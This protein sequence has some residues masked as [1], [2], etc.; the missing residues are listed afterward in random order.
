MFYAEDVID[1]VRIGNNIVD[2]VG[3]YI[4][5]KKSGTSTYMGLCPFHKEHTPSFSVNEDKQL[6]YC[7]GCGAGGTV[8]NFIRNVENVDFP[9][10]L[11]ML[12]KRIGYKLPTAQLSEEEKKRLEY[13]NKLY[14]IHREAARFFYSELQKG[15]NA[16]LATSYLNERKVSSHIRVKYGLGVSP[17]FGSSLCDFLKG[18][19]YNEKE[20]LGSGLVSKSKKNGLL[21]DRFTDRLIFPIIDVQ[22]RIIGFG[23]RIL[24]NNNKETAKYLNSP[25]TLIFNKSNN[26]YSLNFAR[27]SGTRSFILVEGYMDVISLSQAGFNNAVAALGTAFNENHAKVLKRYADDVVILFDSDSA[28][29]KAVLRAIPQ[30]ENVGINPRVLQ[31][32]EAK[33]PDEYIKKF[34]PEAFNKLLETAKS[35]IVFQI[36]V[37][38]KNYNL[39]N[40]K[41]LA[42][43]SKETAKII[44][45]TKSAVEREIY[46]KEASKITGISE[47]AI[48]QD[49]DAVSKS[50]ASY[51]FNANRY[52]IN[53]HTSNNTAYEE[54]QKSIINIITTNSVARNLIKDIV[55]EEEFEDDVYKKMY[56]KICEYDK[57]KIEISAS[58][59]AGM[60]TDSENQRKASEVYMKN[61]NFE[62]NEML[63]KALNDQ[64]YIIKKTNIVSK[65]GK[66]DDPTELQE[67]LKQQKELNK[68]YIKF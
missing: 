12:A 36:E 51:N 34:G 38:K 66:T 24:D 41:E 47:N 46:T 32:K 26:L 2:V 11:E 29:E 8:F 7:F 35:N 15:K 57:S 44:A 40:T 21:Y 63:E 23:G 31:V 67:L 39:S 68:N 9:E 37:K 42:D 14:E 18:K 43:F 5:L 48:A 22:K 30:L 64:I 62:T 13:K 52:K 25:E 65:M 4:Q 49:V 3:S 53:N 17:P 45:H 59:L 58:E 27:Q 16:K 54:A 50:P 56:A 1:D 60:F 55:F 6:Y 28:G 61:I 19:G 33:D 20:L 10:A